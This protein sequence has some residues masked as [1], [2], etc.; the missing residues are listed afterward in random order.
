LERIAAL[1]Q[2]G[3]PQPGKYEEC[4]KKYCPECLQTTDLLGV[5]KDQ[6]C[7]DCKRKNEKLI[8][9]CV[10]GTP[11]P[12][13]RPA[14]PQPADPRAVRDPRPNVSTELEG[15]WTEW[16]CLGYG[17]GTYRLSVLNTLV[18][19]SDR[20]KLFFETKDPDNPR[21]LLRKIAASG[22]DIKNRYGIT[23]EFQKSGG[24]YSGRLTQGKISIADIFRGH[25]VLGT[26]R[27]SPGTELFKLDKVGEDEYK[28]DFL[29]RSFGERWF[30]GKR[31]VV[32]GD[33]AAET[34]GSSFSQL[35]IWKRVR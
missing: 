16:I 21:E 22:K 35:I 33:Y 10:A 8:N 17:A 9:E 6:K 30:G 2:G 14:P 29:E 23:V 1:G 4:L 26:G 15:V 12:V 18:D 24:R 20:K 32:L 13:G 25:H 31:V 7:N 19:D 3:P 11:S 5:A 27:L 28:G 34:H